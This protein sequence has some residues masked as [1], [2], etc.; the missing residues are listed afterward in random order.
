MKEKEKKCYYSATKPYT[1]RKRFHPIFSFI[2]LLVKPFFPKNEF[3]YLDGKP[4]PDEPIFFVSNHTKIY[5][6]V[7]FML[8]YEKPIRT[9]AN[10]YF[11]YFHDIYNH[12][13]KKVLKDRK[14]K[15]ILYP[16]AILLSPLIIAVFRGMEPIP[17][18]HKD[19]RVEITFEKSVETMMEGVPQIIYPER[20]ENPV[21]K[22]VYEFNK[23]FVYAAK[24]YYDK[25]GKLLKFY[26]VY[27]CQSLRKVLIGKPYVYDPA[28]P[29]H[30]QKAV[31]CAYLENAIK[32]MGD[33]LGEHKIVFY[34]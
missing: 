2:R 18:Y 22:Y 29:I 26:P 21:N 20:T 23:G 15:F 24:L 16:L 5:A 17:V 19:K 8:D 1:R 34:G 11:L 7:C 28:M 9:W 31:A 4:S 12:V 33:S 14:P 3:I 30:K 10:Y 13:L 25:T 27:T 6:P 32:E